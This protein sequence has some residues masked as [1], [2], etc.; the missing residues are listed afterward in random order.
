M[1][2]FA[3]VVP[4]LLT[5]VFAAIGFGDMYWKYQQLSAATSEGAR[6][7]IVSRNDPD[8]TNTVI[9]AAQN[10]APNLTPSSFGVTVTS[11]WTPGQTVTVTGTYPISLHIIGINFYDGNLKSSR[12]MRVEQ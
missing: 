8:R 5:I 9:T 10:A 12:T 11:S 1:V 6:K 7:A 2:E 3:L 4:V